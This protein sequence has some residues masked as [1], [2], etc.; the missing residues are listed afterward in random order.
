[1]YNVGLE[2]LGRRVSAA[3]SGRPLLAILAAAVL[4]GACLTGVRFLSPDFTYRAFFPASDPLRMQVERFEDTFGNDDSAVLLIRNPAGLLSPESAEVILEA[5]ERMWLVPNVARV[6]SLSN[7]RWVRAEGD[8]I[9]I[10]AMIPEDGFAAEAAFEERSQAIQSDRLI[11]DYLLS[12]DGTTTMVVGFVRNGAATPVNPGPVISAVREIVADLDDG[13][14]EFHITGRMAVMTG[15][16]ES[17]QSDVQ[18]VLPFVIGTIVLLTALAAPRPGAVLMVLLVIVGSIVSTMGVSGWMGMRI[19]NITAM[20]PQFVL[21]IAVASAVHII[22]GYYR[23]RNRSVE[24]RDAAQTSLQRN[25]VPTLLTALTTCVAFLSFAATDITAIANLGIMVGVGTVIAWLLTYLLVG[26]MLARLPSLPVK[27]G[28]PGAP[29]EERLEPL[30]NRLVNAVAAIRFPI[31]AG[32]V[33]LSI[34]AGIVAFGNTINSNP[35]R[36]FDESFWLRQSSDFA[37]K[38][39]RG[40]QGMEVVVHAG[41]TNG[42]KDPDFMAKVEELQGWISAQ[43]FV[44]RAVSVVDFIK[45]TNQALN[46]DDPAHYALPETRQ[47]MSE[48]LFLYSFNLPE[49]L[50]L[51]NRVS[52]EHDQMRISV[53]WTLYDSAEATKWASRIE[54]RA[55]ELGLEAETTGKMLLF[56]RMNQYVSQA[57]FVSLGIALALISLLLLAVFRSPKLGL[58]SLAA[59]SLPLTMGAAVLALAGRD[60][61][62]GAVVAITVCLGVAVD[63]TI[64]LLQAIRTSDAATPREAIAKGLARVLPAI[65]LTSLILMVG[66]G[67]FMMGDFVPNQN[68]GLM[69]MVILGT[70][71]LL[72]VIFLPA[73]LL[74]LLPDRTEG[75]RSIAGTQHEAT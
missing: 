11:P 51:S 68:F 63:D 5:T 71:W 8:D 69:A 59:N 42:I 47:E 61:D 15:L 54:E 33:A 26:G 19:S 65:T 6:D 30:T 2:S 66:F 38:N 55:S 18:T 39:L 44:A 12:Q 28:A 10:D 24:M 67:A 58:A 50:D 14:H 1:M 16:Q 36:Y 57:L 29:E 9:R 32:T 27:F 64:H 17:A 35:F 48:L 40:S 25:F 56:Q 31:V 23:E 20:V 60:F 74:V 53:R 45:Q 37:E 34:G 75:A 41:E 22:L 21:A 49:G 3:I 13:V 72:D 70:A 4:I 46:E 73:L 62:T 7:Y 52:L 43:P